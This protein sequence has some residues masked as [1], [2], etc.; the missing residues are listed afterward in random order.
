MTE[1]AKA[2][3][4]RAVHFWERCYH[5]C[6]VEDDVSLSPLSDTSIATRSGQAS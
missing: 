3:R 5:A 6:L 1:T 2:N 4:P